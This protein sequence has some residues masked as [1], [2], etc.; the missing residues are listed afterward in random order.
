MGVTINYT[1]A[2]GGGGGG[3]GGSANLG[4]NV[5]QPLG[6]AGAGTDPTYAS[7]QDHVH[8]MPSALQTG[9]IPQASGNY[10][11]ATNTVLTGPF[12]GQNLASGT[13]PT[14]SGPA[15][16]KVT[17]AGT[18][19]LDSVGALSVGDYLF[20]SSALVWDVDG[21][22]A[23]TT[24]LYKGDG[25]SAQRLVAAVP[26]LDFMPAPLFQ[27]GVSIGVMPS[28]TV[29]A[30]GV[31]TYGTGVP[32][33]YPQGCYMWFSAAAL[34]GGS[35]A[36]WYWTVLTGTAGAGLGGTV[37]NNYLP[38]TG[39]AA[40]LAGTTSGATYTSLTAPASPTTT[41]ITGGTHTQTTGVNLWLP[42]PVLTGNYLGNN[43]SGQARFFLKSNNS[44]DV[45]TFQPG[46]LWQALNV[47]TQTLNPGV[48]TFTN[49]GVFNRQLGALNDFVL[50]SENVRTVD[51]SAN[52]TINPLF[53][54]AAGGSGNSW[55]ICE[56][57]IYSFCPRA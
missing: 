2:G 47:T 32:A 16:F 6:T 24:G 34:Y 56:Q 41:G 23:A 26:G 39:S 36:G 21:G 46:P 25:T 51:T 55:I 9:A 52:V 19:G 28:C 11:A 43:G 5:P 22:A 53:N 40:Q 45:K 10:N 33:A 12:T 57:Q 44:A 18:P 1:A 8:A 4:S 50:G 20:Y 37:Y 54:L 30:A 17:V 7:R 42:G 13:L 38:A 27:T 48:M 14:G 29:A 31:L 15:A 49:A 35:L 3:G